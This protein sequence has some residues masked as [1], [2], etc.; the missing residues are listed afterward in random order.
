MPS[1]SR[2]SSEA[3]FE[4]EDL[5]LSS[6]DA[7]LDSK[8]GLESPTSHAFL[9]AP[10]APS[11][12]AKLAS[13]AALVLVSTLAAYTT[14]AAALEDRTAVLKLVPLQY[15]LLSLAIG[16]LGWLRPRGLFGGPRIGTGNGESGDRRLALAV[17]ILSVLSATL[18][19]WQARYMA[20]RVWQAIEVAS[21]PTISMLALLP[22]FGIAS[23]RTTPEALSCT[24]SVAFLVLFGLLGTAVPFVGLALALLRA[25]VEALRWHFLAQGLNGEK[26][27]GFL[28][29]SS[30]VAFGLSLPIALVGS[31]RPNPPAQFDTYSAASYTITCVLGHIALLFALHTFSERVALVGKWQEMVL[32][33]LGGSFAVL[34]CDPELSTAMRDRSRWIRRRLGLAHA[35]GGEPSSYDLETEL[36]SRTPSPATSPTF[37]GARRISNGSGRNTTS[38]SPSRTLLFVPF[39]PLLILLLRSS[40]ST[41]PSLSYAC[42]Y[43]SPSL[44]LSL[45]PASSH[46]LTV[47]LV[48]AYYEEPLDAFAEHLKGIKDLKFVKRRDSRV[49]VYNKGPKSEEELRSALKLGGRDEVIPL[50]NLGREGATYLQHILLHYNSTLLASSGLFPPP[51]SPPRSRI[52]ADHTFFEQPHLAWSDVAGPRMQLVDSDTGFA[53]LGPVLRTDCG[54]DGRDTGNYPLVR[55]LYVL[56]RGKLCPPGG[57]LSAWSGQFVVNRKR[58]MANAYERYAAL[59][60]MLEAPEGHWIHQLWGANG[61]GGPSNPALG[62]HVER[63]WPLIFDCT[64]PRIADECPDDV[65]VKEKCQC[66]DS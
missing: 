52:L 32:V 10:P 44:R 39:L 11:S 45:C 48:F 66:I 27:G 20:P 65:H 14:P 34:F 63:S 22:L 41:T 35:G 4:D 26:S 53:A 8:A 2:R 15:G 47:D 56:F 1:H 40:T 12:N 62:H 28:L 38:P 3:S 6:I 24:S 19:L 54:E 17:G 37:V 42:D 31:A 9:T 46:S 55:D 29:A 33:L 18:G 30:V 49:L 50:P 25:T 59:S 57:Q 5:R 61:S 21:I 64:D 36:E 13:F 43:L 58:I 51:T 60:E 7:L 23:L 16:V